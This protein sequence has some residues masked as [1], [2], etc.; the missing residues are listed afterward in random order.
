MNRLD[1]LVKQKD[2]YIRTE[3]ANNSG[4]ESFSDKV[5]ETMKVQ[6]KRK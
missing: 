2:V 5:I 3:K 1:V 6:A 4:E